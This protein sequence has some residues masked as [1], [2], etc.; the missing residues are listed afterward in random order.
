LAAGVT[1]IGPRGSDAALASLGRAF[2]HGTAKTIGATGQPLPT[3]GAPSVGAPQG[4]IELAV[5]GAHLS[6]MALNH[7]LRALGGLFLRATETEPAYALYALP[8][9]PPKRPGLVRVT[10][11]RGARIAVEV[12][13]LPAEGFG[14]FVAVIPA[15]LGIGTLLL[16]DGSRPKGFL[17]EAEAIAG[18]DDISTFGGWRA[19]SSNC[20]R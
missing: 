7:E 11:G 8:G 19:F 17:C 13:A 15:P 3:P 10:A 16:A 6:G 14:R 18:A 20:D 5:V 1:L 4:C 9:G 2:H 12:W